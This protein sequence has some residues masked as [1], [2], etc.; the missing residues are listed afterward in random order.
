MDQAKRVLLV[1]DDEAI[2]LV[3]AA[4][5]EELGFKVTAVNDGADAIEELDRGLDFDLLM[6]DFHM[7]RVDGYELLHYAR[8]HHYHNP[9]VFASTDSFLNDRDRRALSDCCASMLA[10]PFSFKEFRGTVGAALARVHHRDCTHW[11]DRPE[12]LEPMP[13]SVTTESTAPP[14]KGANGPPAVQNPK[15]QQINEPTTSQTTPPP[16]S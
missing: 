15:N 6:T 13:P 5:F 11:P 3:A 9:I 2:R 16:S 8:E 12:E 14:D 1:E 4:M 10:K 7:P